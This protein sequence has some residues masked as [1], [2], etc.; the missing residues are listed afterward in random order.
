MSMGFHR[1]FVFW[2][3]SPV[4]QPPPGNPNSEGGNAAQNCDLYV[5]LTI[6]VLEVVYGLNPLQD[7]SVLLMVSGD[8]GP[9]IQRPAH[10]KDPAQKAT[11]L[12][13]TARPDSSLLARPAFRAKKP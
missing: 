8:D 13:G 7:P 12:L 6:L 5:A 10:R 3:K 4:Q 1:F 11:R 2:W 9:D